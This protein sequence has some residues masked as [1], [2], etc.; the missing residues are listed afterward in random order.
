MNELE[1]ICNE[2]FVALF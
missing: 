2:V 1:K